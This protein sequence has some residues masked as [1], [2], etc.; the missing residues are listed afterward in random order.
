MAI[1]I[2]SLVDC[3]DLAPQLNDDFDGAWPEFM[4]WDPMASVYYGVAHDIF[5]EFVFV[6]VDSTDPGPLDVRAAVAG[7]RSASVSSARCARYPQP[8]SMY[9]RRSGS[10]RGPAD[11][12]M[13]DPTGA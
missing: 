1:D 10:Q 2:V 11:G 7:C 8:T 3:A 6:A 4:R 9:F 12:S 5:P 13:T